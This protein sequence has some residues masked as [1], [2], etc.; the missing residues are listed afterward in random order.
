MITI[1]SGFHKWFSYIPMGIMCTTGVI[2]IIVAAFEFVPFAPPEDRAPFLA[3]SVIW[4]MAVS[5]MAYT[6]LRMPTKINVTHSGTITL[7]SPVRTITLE[8][9]EIIKF[10][11]DMDGDWMLHYMKGRLDLRY[12]RYKELKPFLSWAVRANPRVQ[13][14][15]GLGA[16][17]YS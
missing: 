5:W 12:F 17:R 1:Q 7:Q 16:E 2:F 13:A 14:P 4:T 3:F 8:P 6:F 9:N 11:C 10:T 15:D